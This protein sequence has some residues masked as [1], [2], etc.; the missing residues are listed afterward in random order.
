[1]CRA[2]QVIRLPPRLVTPAFYLSKRYLVV[3]LPKLVLQV[4]HVL[5]HSL[6]S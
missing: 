4:V 1:M 5:F 2:G 3:L 6:G